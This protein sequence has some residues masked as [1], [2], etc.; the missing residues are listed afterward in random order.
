MYGFSRT[1]TIITL[2]IN[3]CHVD[4]CCYQYIVIY[5]K[6]SIFTRTKKIRQLFKSSEMRNKK[7]LELKFVFLFTCLRLKC[8]SGCIQTRKDR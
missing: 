8:A 5:V 7:C 4:L 2:N 6:Q 3:C 1:S